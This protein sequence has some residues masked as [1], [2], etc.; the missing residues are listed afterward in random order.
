MKINFQ[1]KLTLS[2][3]IIFTVFTAGIVI[4]EQQRA[5]RYKTEALQERL[6]AYADEVSEYLLHRGRTAPMDSL[7]RLMPDNLRLTLVDRSGNVVYDNALADHSTMGNHFDRQEI[8][9]AVEHGSGTMVR[10]SATTNTPYLY[11]AADNGGSLIVRVALPYDVKVQSFLKPDNA[12]L[13]FVI[14]LFIVGIAF[15]YYVGRHFVISQQRLREMEIR[16]K[17]RRLK[18]ELTGNIAHELRTPVTSIRGFLEIVL[19][20]DLKTVKAQEYLQR[21]YYQT[22]ALSDLI[23]DMGLLARLDEKRDTFGFAQ[24]DANRLLEKVMTDTSAALIAKN[25]SFTTDIPQGLTLAGN[26][27]LLY[28]IFR[29]LVDNTLSHAGNDVEIR[30]EVVEVKDGMARFRFADTGKGIEDERPLP[31][32]FERFYRVNEGRTRDT[33]GSGL[34]L[35]IVK[36][37][38]Q[39]HNGTITVRNGDSGGLEFEITLPVA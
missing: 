32:L 17:N 22:L 9:E 8:V 10:T 5:R 36:N 35:S 38:V 3:L 18:Q 26:E 12:F 29:N 21:A 28:S 33:G 14:A 34:G 4:F 2:F 23:S 19:E 11:Y 16:E 20:N 13:Y 30:V 1:Q 6:D 24:V 7:L 39:L 31:L 15:I 27:T 25:I 37:A